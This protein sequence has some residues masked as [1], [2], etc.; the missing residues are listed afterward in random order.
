MSEAPTPQTVITLAELRRRALAIG[1]TKELATKRCTDPEWLIHA[2]EVKED[3][4]RLA[5]GA[6]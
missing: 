3:L 4:G 5:E 1:H 6:R 2:L